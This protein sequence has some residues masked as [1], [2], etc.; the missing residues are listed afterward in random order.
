MKIFMGID[1]GQDGAV[2]VINEKG[3]ILKIY[4]RFY[5]DIGKRK[6]VAKGKQKGEMKTYANK[7]HNERK[8]MDSVNAVSNY[9][10]GR[11]YELKACLEKQ[12]AMK[13]AG[14]SQGI[15]SAFKT[16]SGYGLWRMALM[17]A[18]I[19]YENPMPRSWQKDF[20][21]GVGGL[22]TK[23]KSV[24]VAE[25]LFPND[26]KRFIPTKRSRKANHNI[27]DAV[28]MAEWL[29]RKENG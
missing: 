29:R 28:L 14:I 17:C 9:C 25:R 23:E 10:S 5:I 8:I 3:K 22:D 15:S 1:P 18:A 19:P 7:I 11:N 2:A 24:I 16:G 26:C 20:F 21:Q 12:Q 27:T 6:R 4:F 13:I